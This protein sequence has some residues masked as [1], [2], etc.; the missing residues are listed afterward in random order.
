MAIRLSGINSGLDTDTIVQALVSSYSYKKDKYVKAQTKLSWTKDAWK[1]L[2]TKVYGLYSNISSLR[3]SSAYSLKKTTSSDTTKA[4]VTASNTAATGSQKLNILQVAQS[5]YLTGGK[6]DKGTTTSTTLAELGYTGKATSFQVER[7]DGTSASIDVSSSST[8]GDVINQLKDAGLNASLDTTNN[9]MF[10]S[11]KESGAD[12]DFNLI[13]L[14]SDGAKV[15]SLLGLSTSLYTT[16]ANG[17]QITTG[18]G[19]VYEK[20]AAYATDAAGKKITDASIVENNIRQSLNEYMAASEANDKATQQ[21]SNL[22]SA[23]G[24]AKAYSNTQ[25]FYTKYGVAASEQARFTSVIING[26]DAGSL[27][28][29]SGNIYKAT[30]GTDTKGNAVYGYTDSDG[31]QVMVSKEVTYS[32]NGKTYKKDSEGNY[33]NV[34]DSS[35]KYNG[36][37][38]DLVKDENMHVAYYN[39]QE[40]ISY[41]TVVKEGETPRQFTESDIVEETVGTPGNEKKQYVITVDGNRYVSDSKTGTFVNEN[42]GDEKIQT[43]YSYEQTGSNNDLDTVE[44]AYNSYMDQFKNKGMSE[45]EV[46]TE[47][48]SFASDASKVKSFESAAKDTEDVT[49][50]RAKIVEDV[51]NAYL[52]RGDS[53]NNL[54]ASYAEKIA[55]F[56]EKSKD[57]QAI[58]ETNSAVSNLAAIKD[59]AE[60]DDAIAKMVVTAMNAVDI[61]ANGT[62]GTATKMNGQDAIIKL[63]GVE[64]TNNSNNIQV[65]GLTINAQAVTGDG[66]ENAITITT[67]TDAQ[68]I[69]DKIKDFLT[70]YNNVINEMTKLYNAASSKGYEPLTDDEKDAMSD[71]EVEKWEEKIK[72][73]LLRND[74]TLNGVMNVM[75]SAMAKSFEVNGKRYSLSS[76]GISTLGILNS[77]DNEQYAYHIDGDEDDSNTSGKTDKLMEMINS[78]P[79]AVMSFFQQLSTELYDNIGNKMKSTTLS[80]TYTIYNDK[81]MDKQYKEYTKLIA[82]WEER[83]TEKEDYYYN[84]FTAME[85][86]MTKLNSTQS[87]LSGFF[88]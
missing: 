36:D 22:S 37:T 78:D 84:K 62:A 4:T 69:Y 87:S 49:Y 31:K 61:L 56:K 57:A 28:D 26:S 67:A 48:T 14:D 39:V 72:D 7:G 59:G 64:F 12:A 33:V 18:A 45:D 16:D 15:L 81:Q 27:V 42:N 35:D 41:E 65:N 6:L 79:D 1:S 2:N 38:T 20:Y 40:K 13:G 19:A 77:A 82:E 53:V 21:L 73:S 3:Y 17:N 68:G 63:N 54:V 30:S 86:A 58:M 52:S 8:I 44:N 50:S 55:E 9:R 11:A 47:F 76:F 10:L 5:G 51:H 23:L 71:K 29:S 88:G 43:K 74:S 83:I 46:K 34:N 25:D 75:T 70:E 24:Y 80:S 60:Q 66:D 32:L 85:T